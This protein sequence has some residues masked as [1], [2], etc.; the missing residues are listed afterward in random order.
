M[1]SKL[2][3]EHIIKHI[4]E[5]KP[6]NLL[7]TSVIVSSTADNAASES[8]L[9]IPVFSAILETNSGLRKVTTSPSSS[10]AAIFKEVPLEQTVVDDV[11]PIKTRRDIF[12]AC[13]EVKALDKALMAKKRKDVFK[14]AVM[15]LVILFFFFLKYEDNYGLLVLLLIPVLH[16]FNSVVYIRRKTSINQQSQKIED[17]HHTLK[18]AVQVRTILVRNFCIAG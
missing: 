15:V 9:L 13:I 12:G 11:P 18:G 8:L 1:L 10:E 3:V 2:K 16:F 6:I 7:H 17:P 5:N 14:I 4:L